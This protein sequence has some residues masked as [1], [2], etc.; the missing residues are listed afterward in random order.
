M[1]GQEKTAVKSVLETLRRETNNAKEYMLEQAKKIKPSRWD[2]EQR[3]R[4]LKE[5]TQ[6]PAVYRR[7][8]L[9]LLQSLEALQVSITEWEEANIE[10]P[11]EPLGLADQ[12]LVLTAIEFVILFGISPLFIDGT[13]VPISK[14]LRSDVSEM[15]QIIIDAYSNLQKTD[16][17]PA[18]DQEDHSAHIDL[19]EWVTRL[20]ELAVAGNSTVTD[21]GLLLR[22]RYL[23]DV[24]A[25]LFQAGYA[26]LPGPPD[27]LP[28]YAKLEDRN[29]QRTFELATI[30]E[31]RKMRLRRLF[32]R[33][34]EKSDPF[35]AFEALSLLQSVSVNTKPHPGP[36]WYRRLC[37][38]YM[39]H[40]VQRPHGVQVALNFM[41]NNDNQMTA[42]KLDHISQIILTPPASADRQVT[43]IKPKKLERRAANSESVLPT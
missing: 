3:T 27:K 21:V 30:D 28:P 17:S 5:A 29:L 32:G 19:A 37:G 39:S 24:I 7:Y 20:A 9:Q 18:G 23:A 14:R 22:T 16:A 35:S 4:L 6:D 15:A 34:F 12:K 11:T 40:L 42:K 36:V 33:V 1:S 41:L 2:P 10:E 38:R 25:G 13:G 8:A 31:P 43:G 26:P